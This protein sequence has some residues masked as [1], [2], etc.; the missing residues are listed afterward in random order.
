[1]SSVGFQGL[2]ECSFKMHLGM[3]C[4]RRTRLV[5]ATVTIATLAT[6]VVTIVACLVG[7]RVGHGTRRRS[8][9]SNESKTTTLRLLHL[10]SR[11]VWSVLS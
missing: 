10:L 8:S 9:C 5:A 11:A 1:M 4:A 7:L 2:D 3:V 6:A